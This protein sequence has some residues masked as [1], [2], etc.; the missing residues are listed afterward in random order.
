MRV[1]VDTNVLISAVLKQTSTP[2][3]AVRLALRHGRLL[4]LDPFRG[5][6]ILPPGPFLQWAAERGL[7]IG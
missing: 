3:V 4:A 2:A 5:I 7:H 6:P 1:V